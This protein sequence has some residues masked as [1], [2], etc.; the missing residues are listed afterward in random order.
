MIWLIFNE[1]VKLMKFAPN[2]KNISNQ[3]L[4]FKHIP[5]DMIIALIA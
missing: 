3:I 2:I 5:K 1:I 4:C